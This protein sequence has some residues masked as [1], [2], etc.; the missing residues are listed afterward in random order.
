MRKPALLLLLVCLLFTGCKKEEIELLTQ[1][2]SAGTTYNFYDVFFVNDSVGY[3]C[4]GSK[5]EVGIF[6]K[7]TDGGQTW[8]TADSVVSKCLYTSYFFNA[9]EGFTMGYD[10]WKLYTNDSAKTFTAS[11]GNYSPVNAVAFTNRQYGVR[12]TG[13]GYSSGS[14]QSTSDGGNTWAETLLLNNITDVQYADSNTAYASGFGVIYKSVDKGQTFNP[15]DVRGDFFIDMDFP[16]AQVGYFVGYEGL[17]IKTTDAGASFKTL[18]KGNQPFGKRVHFEAVDFWD[19][20]TGYA[21]GDN[22]LMLKTDNGGESWKTV[23]EFTGVTLR[24]IHLFSSASGIVVGH[25]G[26]I[27]LFK[28]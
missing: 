12:V 14:I 6:T 17:I 10:S 7:T 20:N 25:D 11:V 24:D 21:V 3:A 18:R 23:K 8:A 26:K 1:E 22:G 2:V 27:F 16:S 4:G 13:D 19:E 15:L 5:Y 28:Q 9:Q